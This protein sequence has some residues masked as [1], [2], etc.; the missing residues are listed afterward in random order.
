MACAG[1][2]SARNTAAVTDT[3]FDL[4]LP[5]GSQGRSLAALLWQTRVS[6]RKHEVEDSVCGAESEADFLV[7]AWGCDQQADLFTVK[8]YVLTRAAVTCMASGRV[9]AWAIL[10]SKPACNACR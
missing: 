6:L 2:P 10:A 4:V 7:S 9:A 1:K 5:S 3:F 8:S